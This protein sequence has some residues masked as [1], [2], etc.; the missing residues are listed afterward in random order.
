MSNLTHMAGNIT[1]WVACRVINNLDGENQNF[2]DVV[3]SDIG[4][5]SLRAEMVGAP[6]NE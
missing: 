3:V 2:D 1:S 5:D 4:M 6:R